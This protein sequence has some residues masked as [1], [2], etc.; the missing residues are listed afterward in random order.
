MQDRIVFMLNRVRASQDDAPDAPLTIDRIMRNLETNEEQAN[1]YC[2]AGFVVPR[3]VET[4]AEVTDDTTWLVTDVH[5]QD[6][7]D[8]QNAC[9]GS[10]AASARRLA[11]FPDE[12]GAAVAGVPPAPGD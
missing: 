7:L 12:P 9:V 6:R 1:L 2:T 11:P 4:E 10:D 5:I 3:L 8:F